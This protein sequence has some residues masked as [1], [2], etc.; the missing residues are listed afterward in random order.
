MK[1]GIIIITYNISAEVFLLQI[2]AIKKFCKDDFDILVVD[3][4][5]DKEIAEH[6]R[7]HSAA[8]KIYYIKIYSNSKGSSDSHSFAANFAYQKFKDEYP[9]FFFIDHDCIPVKE[10][11]VVEALSGG[12]V[13]GGIG[14][15]KGKKYPWPGCFY[16]NNNA[17]DNDL[18][19][20]SPNSEFGLDTGGNLYK[21]I[22]K[23]GAECFLDFNESYHENPFY[24][25]KE[26]GH[27]ALIKDETFLHFIAGSNW[28][29][30]NGHNERIASL[31]NV[32]KEKTGL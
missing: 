23:Y 22:E 25:N 17:V 24:K 6:I 31:V 12:H 8:N 9:Y 28:V 14:Q 27:F 30:K 11:S 32:V 16:L 13:A 20:F 10:F 3:N 18:V 19:D 5:D 2:A 21:I 15:D 29:N 7:Y 26:Y 1:V 4:S